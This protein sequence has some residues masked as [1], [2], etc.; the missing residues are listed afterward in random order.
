MMDQP[1]HEIIGTLLAAG[2]LVLIF[3][4]IAGLFRYKDFYIRIGIVSIIDTAGFIL[5][6]A[7]MMVYRGLTLFSLKL[8]IILLFT[9]LLNPIANH[10]II[11]GA[12]TSGY[13]HRKE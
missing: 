12:Y 4:G 2:G 8:G 13:S 3:I 6:V 1:L 9:M 5:C 7:G 10:V 11:R